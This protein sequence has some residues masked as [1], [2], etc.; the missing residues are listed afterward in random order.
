MHTDKHTHTRR[1]LS[2]CCSFVPHISVA[3]GRCTTLGKYQL[4]L[5]SPLISSIGL[6]KALA[7]FW[8][9]FLTLSF[10]VSVRL[11]WHLI[12]THWSK[13][14]AKET[15]IV[16]LMRKMQSWISAAY[17][18][19]VVSYSVIVLEFTSTLTSLAYRQ[20]SVGHSR[21]FSALPIT[22]SGAFCFCLFPPH[23]L[24]LYSERLDD[25]EMYVCTCWPSVHFHS[26]I[27]WLLRILDSNWLAG[28]H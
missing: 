5:S 8:S 22:L 9:Y 23:L 6:P 28:I 10:P 11:C 14:G 21:L 7:V 16:V 13:R 1:A 18:H 27:P 19:T 24:C 3:M 17:K 4:Q 2:E 20:P 26:F 25:D 12:C 15:N